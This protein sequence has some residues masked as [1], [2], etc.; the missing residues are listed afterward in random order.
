MAQPAAACVR[1]THFTWESASLPILTARSAL[2]KKITL[3]AR[4]FDIDATALL[5]D[6]RCIQGTGGT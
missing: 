1:K 6:I 4:L 5:L 2:F 3:L